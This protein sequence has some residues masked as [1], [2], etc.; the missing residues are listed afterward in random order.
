LNDKI[1]KRF[2]YKKLKVKLSKQEN[3]INDFIFVC[4]FLGNDFLP[5]FPS[6]DINKGGLDILLDAYIDI[7]TELQVNL[8]NVTKKTVTIDTDFLQMF[9]NFIAKREDYY[10][11]E[12]LPKF[13]ERS[14]QRKCF[15][16]DPYD[17]EVWEMENLKNIKID[18][19]IKLGSDSSDLWKFR[20]YE[21]YLNC[22]TSQHNI[23]DSLC[24]NYLEGLMWVANY[25]FHGSPCWK[26]Q[27]TYTHA[28]FIS[29]LSNYIAKNSSKINKI[30]F[31][32]NS[33]LTP[34]QQLLA[35]LPPACSK[36]LPVNYRKIV[37][38]ETSEII[39]LF[40]LKVEL[41]MINKDANWKCIAMIPC[42]DSTRIEKATL[43]ITLT[44]EE[45]IRNKSLKSYEN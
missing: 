7:Y 13:K 33:P 8:I 18:D 25:Y 4:F 41:D 28:P 30:K 9:V 1:V 2:K 42:V 5:H 10:F 36:L 38:D 35:V 43:N 19:P 39:D 15:S 24:N 44:K 22:S 11:K 20:Y 3:M 37:H 45:K 27:Y 32:E 40:P 12:I 34:C 6:I 29:D 16:S 23:I 21:H 26:W 14:K 17:I 31:K